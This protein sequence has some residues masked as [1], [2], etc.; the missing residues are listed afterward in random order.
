MPGGRG[1]G[2]W[3]RYLQFASLMRETVAKSHGHSQA[4]R[5][6]ASAGMRQVDMFIVNKICHMFYACA[7]TTL[8]VCDMRNEMMGSPKEV[9]LV[10]S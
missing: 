2:E 6:C 4:R 10:M 1:G 7:W 3:G 5:T 8:P 9:E